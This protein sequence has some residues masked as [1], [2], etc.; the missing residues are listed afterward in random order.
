MQLARL[1]E[2]LASAGITRSIQIPFRTRRPERSYQYTLAT[3][4]AYEARLPSREAIMGVADIYAE[5][6][7]EPRDRLLACVLALLI[8][9][10]LRIGEVLTL[11]CDCFVSEGQGDDGK[12]GI[13]FAKEKSVERRRV[14]ETRWLTTAQ[15]VLARATIAEV[16][17]LTEGPRDRAR[18]LEAHPETVP[19][20]DISWHAELTTERVAELLGVAHETVKG[21]TARLP[22]RRNRV[23]GAADALGYHAADV[24][25]YLHGQ[26]GLLWVVDRGDGSRQML[27]DTLF[28]TFRNAFADAYRVNSLR[29]DNVVE[30]TVNDFLGRPVSAR[31][32]RWRPRDRALGV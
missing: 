23:E 22:R 11:P 29:V 13:R 15:A 24:M 7:K 18:V 19:L 9:T 12:W 21:N 30:R 6:A 3:R 26:R 4:E 25:Q 17:T 8:A 5:H 14:L 2:V 28:I 27:S 31:R 32:T 16:L 20:P 1:A 10:G